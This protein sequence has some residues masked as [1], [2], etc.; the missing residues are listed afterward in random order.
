MTP[1]PSLPGGIPE[2]AIEAATVALAN[3][4]GFQNNPVTKFDRDQAKVAVAAALPHLLEAEREKIGW[5][6]GC[7]NAEVCKTCS[8]A[9]DDDVCFP[10]ERLRAE[11]ER[12]EADIE[13]LRDELGAETVCS[14][15]WRK[16]CEAAEATMR[17]LLAAF[18]RMPDG[19]LKEGD[20]RYDWWYETAPEREAARKLLADRLS[21]EGDA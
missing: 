18:C 20:P 13:D 3:I 17:E 8:C 5:V 15:N 12:A 11:H 19:G 1:D 14:E 10:G 16:R 2:K 9:G 6:V 21:P 4:D 7:P